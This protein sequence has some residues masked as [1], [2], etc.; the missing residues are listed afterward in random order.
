MNKIGISK[1]EIKEIAS[2]YNITDEKVINFITEVVN[3]NNSIIEQ[4]LNKD[5]LDTISKDSALRTRRIR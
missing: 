3:T 4:Y 1:I 5:Y 2:K